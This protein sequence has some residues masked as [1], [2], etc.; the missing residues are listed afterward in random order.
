M[1]RSGRGRMEK[2]TT[3]KKST[4]VKAIW[5]GRPL[6]LIVPPFFPEARVREEA[7]GQHCSLKLECIGE[8]SCIVSEVRNALALVLDERTDFCGNCRDG[9]TLIK[10]LL[11]SI[12]DGS[13]AP[14]VLARLSGS[15]EMLVNERH[16]RSVVGILDPLLSSM[17]FL[18][19]EYEA[20]IFSGNCPAGTC[21]KLLPA[22]C[23]NACPTGIDIPAYLALTAK[24]KYG[25]AL[26]LIRE[27]NPFPWVCGLICPHPCE[28]ACVR[29]N[30]DAPVN[31]RYLKAF[32]AE[33]A[34]NETICVPSL[35]PAEK[36]EA[37]VAVIGAGPAGLS[38]A[39]FLARMGYRVTV[40][41]ALPTAGG[42]LV[43]GIPEYRLPRSVVKKEVDTIRSLGVEIKTGVTIGKDVSLEAL[44]NQGY[45]AFFMA[46]GAHRGY[47][48]G[49]GGEAEFKPVYDAIT[50]LKGINSGEKVK[51][52]E[53]V[54]VIG[55][56]NSAMDAAR[57][58]IR[59]GCGEVHLAYRRTRA[60][61]PANPQE[62]EEAIEE[63][64]IFH[65]LTVPIRVGGEAGRVGYMECLQAE[66]GEPDASGRRRPVPVL[67]SNFR[68]ETDAVIAAIGQEP[69]FRPFAA[70]IPVG[71][72]RRNLILT[73]SPYTLTDAPDIFA[74]GDAVTGPATV[75]RAIAAGKQA[76][77]DI[78]HYLEGN[79]GPAG[80]FLNRKRKRQEFVA[81][82]ALEKAAARRIP[83]GLAELETRKSSFEPVERGYSEDEARREASRC[84]RCDVCVRCGTCEQVCREEMKIEALE[85]REIAPEERILSDY[86]RPGERCIGCGACAISCPTGAMQILDSGNYREL[87]LCG[88][89]LNRIEMVHCEHCGDAF[90]PARY[91]EHVV[92][93]SDST[94]GKSVDRKFCPRCARIVRA[95]EWMLEDDSSRL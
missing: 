63:G 59:L 42:L 11:S 18:Q 5:I 76:A 68:I 38:S 84:L 35:L 31:I 89:I 77:L 7:E 67:D 32:V 2:D 58:C 50:F 1:T 83:N 65:F 45:S 6:G 81:V 82:P 29:G 17:R 86:A 13:S 21:G 66:L 55:G 87:S 85:F 46:I 71:V 48:L 69:D 8:N 39:Y 90:V 44:R 41:E 3:S 9:L 14:D 72:S 28:T 27:D 93:V 36:R 74:G 25:E 95:Q 10:E 23:Q 92:K 79:E 12:V 20:H 64:V 56:G 88:T 26:D 94:M 52:G 75:V 33:Q 22:P 16:C 53:R 49:I 30:L 70:D 62:V 15:A 51:P 57:T 91:L 54:V 78:D 4:R 24:G 43:Y 73:K 61:M 47:R 37:K 34:E 80:I 60:E 40:F 19:S